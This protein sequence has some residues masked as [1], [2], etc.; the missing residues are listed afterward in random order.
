MSFL[1]PWLL[2]G[3]PLM[4]LPVIIHLVNRQ[5]HRT[6]DWA[7]MRFLLD[8]RRMS[9][10]MA[11]LRQWLILLMRMLI[12]AGIVLAISRP[13]A[14]L[15]MGGIAGGGN[16]ITGILLDRSASMEQQNRLGGQTKRA[17]ALAK[18]RDSLEKTGRTDRILLIDGMLPRPLEIASTE[19]LAK[20]PDSGPTSTSAS[21]P[22][23]LEAALDHIEV[24]QAGQADLWICT[25]L[26]VND[27]DPS[28]G[29]W[30]P[31]RARAS[32]VPGLRIFLLAYP[33]DA[34]EDYQVRVDRVQRNLQGSRGELLLDFTIRRQGVQAQVKDEIQLEFTVNSTRSAHIFKMETDEL[35]LKGHALPID[36]TQEAGWGRISLPADSNLR[37]NNAYFVYAAS[38]VQKTVV[39][40]G[41]ARLAEL[42]QITASSPRNPALQYEVQH[43]EPAQVANIDWETTA[44][45]VWHAPL[46]DGLTAQQL[47]NYVEAGG[48]ALFLPPEQ[49][50]GKELFGIR[51]TR[52]KDTPTRA[53]TWRTD[54]GLLRN[55]QDG[56]AL[57]LGQTHIYRHCHLQGEGTPLAQLESGRPLLLQT[58]LNHGSAWFL[59]T[60]PQAT[61]SSL[62]RDGIS[63]YVMLHRA[64]TMGAKNLG[65]ARDMEA[66][67]GA[68][69]EGGP[70][71][72]LDT[73]ANSTLS[74]QSLHAGAFAENN[75][76]KMTALNR[77]AD[78][79]SP[80]VLGDDDIAALLEG[81]EYKRIDDTA[82]SLRSLTDEIWKIFLFVA[83]LAL[84]AEAFLC[85]PGRK[86]D[87]PNAQT[88]LPKAP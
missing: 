34:Q 12:I 11:R 25:D 74:T 43:V 27:W 47:R 20:L 30:E 58:H 57:P 19:T 65:D 67:H 40:T 50:S 56:N 66:A 15:W 70:W 7:A 69:A 53:G 24:N 49:P 38:P 76:S 75:T 88:L 22:A 26:R 71:S 5:R 81:V 60:L 61:H 73:E 48:S 44:N 54:S 29:R 86:T 32:R 6:V 2:Y 9:T 16:H 79:D 14:G 80:D 17:T 39:V 8:A 31:I 45:L 82:G 42:V 13:L 35:K 51:W 41:D 21:V 23:M 10:G 46:P 33:E 68:L 36:P 72:S 59:A 52:W 64:I 78:E 18:L 84:L 77:P 85:L 63:F 3:L 37:N 1:Q 62:A 55:T 83:S 4:A 28:S 87:K